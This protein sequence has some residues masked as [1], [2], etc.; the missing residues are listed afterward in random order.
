MLTR[1]ALLL[2]LAPGARAQHVVELP[3]EPNG[4]SGSPSIS[5]DGKFVV[6]ASRASNFVADDQKDSWDVFL[7]ERASGHVTRISDDGNLP[8]RT[9]RISGDGRWVVYLQA[10]SARA[11][12]PGSW[13]STEVPWKVALF[14]RQEHW[15]RWLGDGAPTLETAEHPSA[16]SI[17]RDGRRLVFQVTYKGAPAILVY[18]TVGPRRVV[19]RA[20][21]EN[22]K[23]PEGL[24]ESFLSPSGQFLVYAAAAEDMDVPL[25]SGDAVSLN[26]DDDRHVFRRDLETGATEYVSHLALASIGYGD[27]GNP[28]VSDDGRFVSY[29]NSNPAVF[30]GSTQVGFV[31]DLKEQLP[32]RLVPVAASGNIAEGAASIDWLSSDGRRA[33]VSTCIPG[34]AAIPEGC[35]ISQLLLRDL[36]SSTWLL[37]SRSPDGQPANRHVSDA[38]A[39]DNLSIIAFASDAT[40][41]VAK[42]SNRCSD[43]FLFELAMMRTTR[44][45]PNAAVAPVPAKKAQTEPNAES[46][47][48]SISRD[49]EFVAFT[50]QASNFD[51]EDF[52]DSWDVFLLTIATRQVQRLSSEPHDNVSCPSISG[53]GRWILWWSQAQDP[54]LRSEGWSL[55][56]VERS[57]GR[58]TSVPGLGPDLDGIWLEESPSVSDDGSRVVFR[59]DIYAEDGI[60]IRS[61]VK[62][63]DRKS[64]ATSIVSSGWSGVISGDG[65]HV[66][67]MSNDISLAPWSKA[68]GHTAIPLPRG[69][70][71]YVR[72]L[73]RQETRVASGLA[74]ELGLFEGVNLY[75]GAIR[76]PL[77]SKDGSRIAFN[78]ECEGFAIPRGVLGL[79]ADL[80]GVDPAPL[81]ALAADPRTFRGSIRITWIA[82]N[83]KCL[84][85]SSNGEGFLSA[86][87]ARFPQVFLHDLDSGESSPISRNAQDEFANRPA[88][89]AVASEDLSRVVFESEADNLVPG[90]TN[91]ARD[92]FI[93]DRST[94]K[95]TRVEARH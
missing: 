92:I 17:A 45:V 25:P 33:L 93:V 51:E 34:I 19:L 55:Q 30:L 2:A 3:R 47:G 52:G 78:C 13:H 56:F 76:D 86:P 7:F 43:I 6:F 49:G 94:G 95:I 14:D 60:R 80:G 40:N 24:F 31:S 87:V 62:V 59:A 54:E 88:E 83:G 10:Q 70:N 18:N 67:F 28:R 37:A 32:G 72:N 68:P 11:T 29:D 61:D 69:N 23:W 64:G 41:L 39:A 15:I 46:K 63:Y 26:Y 4:D 48:S 36:N 79:I 22:G 85:V 57:S 58:R 12:S 84:L 21:N 44:I 74:L 53:D 8:A 71:L 27:F 77:L 73:I 5:D 91:N 81:Y 75:R 82:P 89:S 50:S 1:L 16:P 66:A 20:R 9:P 38:T 35:A 42:D 65:E 90:D